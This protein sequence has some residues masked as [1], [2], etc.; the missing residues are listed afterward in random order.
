MGKIKVVKGK[1]TEREIELKILMLKAGLRLKDIAEP[2][3]YSIHMVCKFIKGVRRSKRLD[4]Y[5]EELRIKL[6]GI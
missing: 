3:G 1:I 4:E 6:R 2:T 5:F